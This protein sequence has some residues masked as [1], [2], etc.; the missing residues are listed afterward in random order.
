MKMIQDAS[1]CKLDLSAGELTIMGPEDGMP[2]AVKAVKELTTKGFCSLAYGDDFL[3]S[4]MN[5]HPIYFSELIG[6][7][8]MVIRAIKD[9]L[10]VELNIPKIP[11]GSK[12]REMTKKMKVGF[13]GKKAD[14]EKAKAVVGDIILY[15]HHDITHGEEVVHE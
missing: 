12:V 13:A 9:K 8:G 14:V 6:K 5:I 4:D 11:Q 1:E 15:Y 3:E 7:Q 10:Q 2:I